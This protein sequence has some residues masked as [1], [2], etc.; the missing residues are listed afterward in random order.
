[1]RRDRASRG[2]S[3]S[4]ELGDDGGRGRGRVLSTG[5]RPPH[6][7][8]VGAGGERPPRRRDPDLIVRWERGVPPVRKADRLHPP[9]DSPRRERA[10]PPGRK[11]ASLDPPPAYA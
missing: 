4:A 3:W 6:D 11:P 2:L 7:Q 10:V 8:V 1:S 9:P 5:D